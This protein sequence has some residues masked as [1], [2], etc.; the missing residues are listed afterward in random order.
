MYSRHT[1][2]RADRS[3]CIW[4][5]YSSLLFS[6]SSDSSLRLRGQRQECADLCDQ[7]HFHSS[8]LKYPGISLSNKASWMIFQPSYKMWN[9]SASSG[10]WIFNCDHQLENIWRNCWLFISN[11]VSPLS[12]NL[13]DPSSEKAGYKGP[14]NYKLVTSSCNS[15]LIRFR[16]FSTVSRPKHS[17]G[18]KKVK[19]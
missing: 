12:R 2:D 6:R 14:T 10:C 1:Q 13:Y 19:H 16:M 5:H 8:D 4:I 3:N 15:I 11:K 18:K 7:I 9:V 17:S